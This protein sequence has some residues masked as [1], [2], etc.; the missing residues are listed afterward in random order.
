MTVRTSSSCFAM[1]P[2]RVSKPNFFA[3]S[4]DLLTY[5]SAISRFCPRA[6]RANV[7]SLLISDMS[8]LGG[9]LQ[10]SHPCEVCRRG[11]TQQVQFFLWPRINDFATAQTASADSYQESLRVPGQYERYAS[12]SVASFLVRLV[13]G[14]K[15]RSWGSWGSLLRGYV[16]VKGIPAGSRAS[17][18]AR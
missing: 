4:T 2:T 8:T 11:R 10:E 15:D 14:W 5:L 17:Q 9:A 3:K 18:T 6:S 7:R 16:T 13:H 12:A 1:C